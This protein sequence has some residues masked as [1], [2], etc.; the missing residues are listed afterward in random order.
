MRE[1]SFDDAYTFKYSVR[2]GT[3][4]ERLRDH[5]PDEV[6]G[7]RLERLIEVVRDEARRKHAGRVGTVH[8]ALVER[9]ARRGGLMLARTRANFL[10]LLD[11]PPTSVGEYHSVRLSGTTGSTFTGVLQTPQ[12]A[13]L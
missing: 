11:L 7:A 10:V 3:P 1:A 2:E 4:A 6:A 13:V 12:L 9:P 8:E 5:L